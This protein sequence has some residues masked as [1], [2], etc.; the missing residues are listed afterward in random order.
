ML[1]D[2]ELGLSSIAAVEKDIIVAYCDLSEIGDG[3]I[4]YS[5]FFR[6][7]FSWHVRKQL[8]ARVGSSLL[9]LFLLLF[10]L[11]VSSLSFYGLLILLSLYIF[12][13]LSSS[14]LI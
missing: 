3:K 5:E 8:Q 7:F 11:M 1:D 6:T 2:P 10:F 4:T 12:L 9:P 13:C 14:F